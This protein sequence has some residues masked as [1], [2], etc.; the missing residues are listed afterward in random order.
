M[1]P[2]ELVDRKAIKDGDRSADVPDNRKVMLE[3]GLPDINDLKKFTFE[4]RK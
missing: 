1:K 2:F 4:M 3:D